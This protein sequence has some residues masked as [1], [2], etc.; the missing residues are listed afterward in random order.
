MPAILREPI[1]T[2]AGGCRG[3][4]TRQLAGMNKD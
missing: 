1:W 3:T 4:M 2:R